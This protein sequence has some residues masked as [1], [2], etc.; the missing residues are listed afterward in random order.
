MDPK[1]DP[2][3]P[4]RVAFTGPR[5]RFLMLAVQDSVAAPPAPITERRHHTRHT[6]VTHPKAPQAG[7]LSHLT[8]PSEITLR[9]PFLLPFPIRAPAPSSTATLRVRALGHHMQINAPFNA[10]SSARARDLLGVT[11]VLNSRT[12]ATF[13]TY[14]VPAPQM[15]YETSGFAVPGDGGGVVYKRGSGPG[16]GTI[17]D[18]SGSVFTIAD[19]ERAPSR[20]FGLARGGDDGPVIA[21]VLRAYGVLNAGAGFFVIRTTVITGDKPVTIRGLNNTDTVFV[22]DVAG[23]MF[24]HGYTIPIPASGA[25][26]RM[27]NCRLARSGGARSPSTN[28]I[29]GTALSIKQVGGPGEIVLDNITIDAF[30]IDSAWE[31]GIM[32]DGPAQLL[33]FNNVRTSGGA[34]ETTT[35]NLD[36][37]MDIGIHIRSLSNDH[38]VYQVTFKDCVLEGIYHGL[39]LELAGPVGNTGSI[40]GVSLLDCGG[41]TVRGAWIRQEITIKQADGSLQDWNPPGFW[42]ERCNF[43]GAYSMLDADSLGEVHIKDNFHYIEGAVDRPHSYVPHMLYIGHC[44]HGHITGNSFYTFKQRAFF[45]NPGNYPVRLQSLINVPEAS[46]LHI[47]G[48]RLSVED[49]PGVELGYGIILGPD[50]KMNGCVIR[51]NFFDGGGQGHERPWP[52]GD[53]KRAFNGQSRIYSEGFVGPTAAFVHMPQ[54]LETALVIRSRVNGEYSIKPVKMASADANGRM[55]LYIQN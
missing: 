13:A 9:G 1:R 55:V 6:P 7:A 5:E 17:T 51:D 54:E 14:T 45:G 15:F 46:F 43:Q 29:P 44:S 23:N 16:V 47:T 26:F 22:M 19:G 4:P 18:A 34:Y 37:G 39:Y 52:W 12:A 33:K 31:K 8:G 50:A 40:E 53:G 35:A 32:I 48:N 30:S 41:R 27:Y 2:P 36:K 24:D 42:M 28:K 3:R 49:H 25:S 38:L 20:A 11:A 10:V 21:A